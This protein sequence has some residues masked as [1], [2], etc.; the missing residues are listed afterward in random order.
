MNRTRLLLIG[1]VALALGAI[2]SYAVYRAL[3]TRSGADAAPGVEVLVAANDIAVGAKVT[4]SDVRL[5]RF[6]VADL[7]SNIFHLKTSVVGR[8][9]ILP[10]AR[11]EFFLPN[12]LA[13]EN[14]GSGMQSLIPPG[15]R[16]VSVRVN[17]VIGVAGF[18]TPGTRV[19]VLLTGNPSGAP[20][21]QTTTV[22]ENVAVIATGQKLERN[23]AGEPQL[24][25]VITLLV[26][27]DDAQKLT[28]ATSQGKIQLALRNPLDTKQQ[29]LN[30]V[31]TGALYKG[32]PMPTPAALRSKSTVKHAAAKA[33]APP[34]PSVYSVEVIKGTKREEVTKF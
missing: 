34:P 16:A 12:K 9:A 15:M 28:L 10:I 4:E 5:V 20:E 26:S 19:D 2:V 7:P 11:G 13:G 8:G 29:E 31:G 21:Q 22:L 18:V 32:V 24:T 27:P 30:S 23:N 14:A 6:P 33:P 3:Q 17:E 25:P 1:F